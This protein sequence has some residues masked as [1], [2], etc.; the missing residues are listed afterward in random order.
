M[1]PPSR[2]RRVAVISLALI[3]I[4]ALSVVLFDL[5]S[6]IEA[7]VEAAT[8]REFS[9]QGDLD[10]DFSLKPRIRAED[11]VLGNAS[12]SESP[13]MLE[14]ELLDFRIDLLEL[15]KRR[16]VFPELRLVQP[17]LLLEKDVDGEPNWVFEEKEEKEPAKFP[18]IHR[19][20]IERGRLDYRAP[21]ERAEL[22]VAVATEPPEPP[23]TEQMIDIEGGGKY[24][25]EAFELK[26]RTGSVFA[27]RD[28]A[29]PFPL[30][31]KMAVG[32]T[33]AA[34]KGTITDP[35]EIKGLDLKLTIEGPDLARLYSL[36]GVVLPETP[37]YRLSGQLTKEGATWGFR[38]FA[39]RMGDSDLSG[40]ATV[41]T[42]RKR[43]FLR[44]EVTSKRL[45][46]DDLGPL[47][48]APPKTSPGET[49]SPEQKERA[50]RQEA[51]EDVLPDKPFK[52]DR[53]RAMDADVKFRGKQIVGTRLP[54][55]DMVTHVV[56]EDGVV[57]LKPLNFGV[58]GGDLASNIVLDARSNPIETRAELR[59]R[60]LRLDQLFPDVKLTKGSVGVLGGRAKLAM[61]GNSPALMLG[62]ANGD[63]GL[64]MEG[65][66]ISN[67]LIEFAGIDIAEAL[68]LYV[69]KD[70]NIAIRCLVGDF[71]L[72]DGVA[73]ANV[74]VFDTTD[75]IVTGDGKI[76]FENETLHLV[77]YPKPKDMSILAL[78][79]PLTITGTFKHPKASP[80]K[81]ALALK[82]G[83]ALALGA[84]VGPLA[85]ILPLIETGPGKDSECARLIAQAKE[86]R[87][88]VKPKK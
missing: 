73:L 18:E 19:F 82:G 1:A 60:N 43:K 33:R 55:D 77:L 70:K 65:G 71:G 23:Q 9:I 8:G 12:W 39:G 32:Q 38:D 40:T 21:E 84:L 50:A 35:Q 63:L 6:F 16:I 61:R 25:G 37:P 31:L 80:D 14:V 57:T 42:A 46:F 44:G 85:A 7:R 58:A 68:S 74:F 4:F 53:L 56:L 5:K 52:L 2:G 86:V 26:G 36:T 79:V 76:S 30:D 69:T 87:E 15:I 64:A 22:T 48:G 54:L 78:R 83:A 24:N 45:D 67:L 72:K 3:A 10:V 13:N 27:L 47:V 17:K 81:G 20:V 62:S 29:N 41:D 34:T 49:A 88:P 11:I 51:R 59:A 28:R 75:T 66:E